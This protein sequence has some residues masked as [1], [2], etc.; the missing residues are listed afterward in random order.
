MPALNPHDTVALLLTDIVDSTAHTER[1]GAARSAALWSA[2]DRIARDLVRHWRGREIDKSDGFL[3]L[4]DHAGDALGCAMAYHQALAG[5]EVPLRARAGLHVG[6]VT[7][8]DNP[9]E[10]VARGAKP[11]EVDGLGKTIAARLMATAVGGQTLLTGEARAA[12]NGAAGGTPGLRLVSHGHWRLKGLPEPMEL[13]EAGGADAPFTPPPDA[14]KSYRVVRQGDLWQ[15]AREVRH[16]LPA[17][18]DTFVGRQG[19]LQALAQRFERGARMVSLLGLGGSGKTRLALRFGR[20]W[21]G[22]YPGGVWF[23]DLAGARDLEGLLRAVAL[24]LDL[25]LGRADPTEQIGHAIAGRGPCLVIFDNFEQVA[26]L[27]EATLGRWLDRAPQARLLVTTR[28]L[29]CMVGEEGMNLPPLD[30]PEAEA[31]FLLRARAARQHYQPDADDAAAISTLVRLLDGLPLAIELAAARV[32]MLAPRALLARMRERFKLLTSGAGRSDRQATLRAAFDWSWDLMAESDRAA[33]AQ[34]SV[35]EGGFTL[36]AAQA[37]LDLAAIDPDAWGED[38]VG[39]LVDKSFVRALGDDRFDLLASVQDYAAEHLRSA[40]RFAGSGEVAAL[41]ARQRHGAWF[42]ALGPVRATAQACADLDNLLAACRRALRRGD[43][44]LAAGALDGAWA[45]LRRHGPIKTGLELAEA[46]CALAG[47]DTRAAGRA[48]LALGQALDASGRL[49]DSRQA[50]DQALALALLAGDRACEA[51]ARLQLAGLDLRDGRPDAAA[52]G[53]AQVLSQ[54]RQLGLPSLECAA[55]NG[56][57]NAAMNGGAM[58]QAR[59]HYLACLALAR[60]CG[61]RHWQGSALGNLGGLDATIGELAGALAQYEAALDIARAL[62]DRQREGFTLANLGLLHQMQGRPA[63]AIAAGQQALAVARGLGHGRLECTVLC[64]L[65]ISAAEQGDTAAALDHYASALRVARQV[66]DR[67]L[68][69]QCLGYLGLVQARQQDFDNGRLHLAEGEALL[70]QV[71]DP[72]GLG[73]L[74]CGRAECEWRAERPGAAMDAYTE[75]RQLAGQIQ[76]GPSSELGQALA[77]VAGL[78]GLA[79]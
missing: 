15:P 4:F 72:P 14:A 61:D 27:A 33:L 41:A 67:R 22:D 23:C 64:N 13:F 7:L 71:A 26:R 53:H 45:A 56:M 11:V 76:A 50:I 19:A 36:A 12:L 60:H 8:R 58:D 66:A 29:L 75:A 42:A 9:A 65:G 31:L 46:V 10:D 30:A 32:R 2:H 20:A 34:L 62:G 52:A 63:Q 70:R 6:R 74:L 43:P 5:L 35:F 47:L 57:G 78:V 77:R 40:G 28:E 21:L 55:L 37:V 48:Q 39:S 25:P 17:E 38:A 16:S 49:A 68:E 69:G 1:L 73:V 24:G 44:A 59:T 51:E 79:A 3:L 18:R 54:A